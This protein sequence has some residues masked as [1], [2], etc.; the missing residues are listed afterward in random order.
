MRSLSRTPLALAAAL[1][2]ALQP[3]SAAEGGAVS[4][5]NG[6]AGLA[7]AY[8]TEEWGAYWGPT[9]EYSGRTWSATAELNLP[10]WHFIGASVRGDAGR[11]SVDT[12]LADSVY[13][14]GISFSCS[15]NVWRA[16]ASIFARHPGWGRFRANY[17]SGNAYSCGYSSSEGVIKQGATVT[18]Y[19]GDLEAYL[20]RWTLGARAARQTREEDIGYRSRQSRYTAAVSFYPTNEWRV[21][22]DY[23]HLPPS[24]G[25]RQYGADVEYQP[26]WL[27]DR[28]GIRAGYQR[29]TSDYLEADAWLLR[30][31]YYFGPA[32]DLLAR[33]RQ[34]R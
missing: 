5:I 7:F 31:S 17:D 22:A 20:G 32:F 13:W 16:G 26:S 19:G 24:R 25:Q 4:E 18:S 10:V 21:S 14:P 1:L 11:S 33:D 9:L 29:F 6:N 28:W 3:V 2:L 27:G 15:Y 34:L 30:V 8:G 12:D 23:T